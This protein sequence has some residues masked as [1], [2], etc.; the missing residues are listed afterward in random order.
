MLDDRLISQ[1]KIITHGVV[2]P[3]IRVGIFGSQVAGTPA[4]FSD[5]DIAL[6]GPVELSAGLLE[7][8]KEAFENSNLPTFTDV[9]D[10][11]SVSSNFRQNIEKEIVWL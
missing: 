1:V 7:R 2:P 5:I 3:K 8:V 9:I 6:L 4:K 10:L 11:N